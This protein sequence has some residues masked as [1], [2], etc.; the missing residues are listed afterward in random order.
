MN[1]NT[2]I[3]EECKGLYEKKLEIS[4][5]QIDVKDTIK[6]LKENLEELDEKVLRVNLKINQVSNEKTRMEEELRKY[7]KLGKQPRGR[8]SQKAKNDNN[9]KNSLKDSQ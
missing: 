5:Q 9:T 8:A 6:Q 2:L 4:N 1:E 3:S 7:T